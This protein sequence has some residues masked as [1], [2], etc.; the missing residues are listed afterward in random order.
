MSTNTRGLKA[1]K[2]YETAD[3][4]QEAR[5]RLIYQ[6][7]CMSKGGIAYEDMAIPI[8]STRSITILKTKV[9]RS[10]TPNQ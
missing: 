6:S 2:W 9:I 1:I 3:D 8:R 5:A 10:T 7:P 4:S